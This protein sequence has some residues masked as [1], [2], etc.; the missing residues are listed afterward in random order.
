MAA[1]FHP[2]LLRLRLFTFVSIPYSIHSM[3]SHYFHLV[4]RSNLCGRCTTPTSYENARSIEH[5]FFCR[6]KAGLVERG[7]T[8]LKT[9]IAIRYSQTATP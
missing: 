7:G 5:V 6:I 1:P 4:H 2:S 3:L 9:Y 8:A